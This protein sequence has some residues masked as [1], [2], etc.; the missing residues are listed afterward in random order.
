MNTKQ[1]LEMPKLLATPAMLRTAQENPP[2]TEIKKTWYSNAYPT[3]T[4]RYTTYLRS[5]VKGGILK[6]S[7]FQPQALCCRDRRPVFELYVDRAK[8]KFLTYAPAEKKWYRGKLDRLNWPETYY[9]GGEMWVTVADEKRILRYFNSQSSGGA[10]RELLHFQYD[11]REKEL[12]QRHAKEV[13]PWDEVMKQ[14]RPLPKDWARWVDKVG[15][16]EQFIFYEYRHGGAKP[17]YCSYCEK[18][19]PIENPRHNKVGCCLCCHHEIKFKAVGRVGF[20]DTKDYNVFLLQRADCGFV[21]RSFTV[22]RRYVRGELKTPHVSWRETRRAF[23]THRGA[24]VS[25]YN[26]G[27]YKQTS[28]R[29]VKTDLCGTS[30]WS[31]PTGR[32]Y[33]RTLPDLVKRGLSYTGLMEYMRDGGKADP[34]YYLAVLSK[35]PQLEQIVKA[36]L[37][38]LVNECLLKSYDYL[39]LLKNGSGSLTKMLGINTRELKRLRNSGSGL[40]YLKW[41][42]L[43]HDMDSPIPDE[44]IDWF[45]ENRLSPKDLNFIWDRMR[46]IQVRN[47]MQ[48]QMR[49]GRMG[50]HD[51]LIKWKDYLSMAAQF[52]YDLNDEIVYRTG[53][54]RKQHDALVKKCHEKDRETRARELMQKYPNAERICQT[55]PEKYSYTDGHYAVVAPT[56]LRDI[57]AEGD[58]LHHCIASS[59]RY[60]ERMERHESYILFLR[61]AEDPERHYYTMEVEPNG[62]VRQIRT[63]YDRQNKDIEEAREFLREWQKVLAERLTDA[64]RER[65]KKSSILRME[66]FAE[67]RKEQV[68]VHTGDLAGHLLVDVLTADLLEAA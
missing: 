32:V 38:V 55:L 2:K 35:V 4:C 68:R 63:E 31:L 52:H 60:L 8:D 7:L 25:A 64:D 28:L 37:P 16:P 59:D 13:A 3:V 45:M 14:I 50:I 51:M 43:E 65:A 46:P 12:K 57:L 26:W 36:N 58:A 27:V 48:A 15:I 47:Y 11:V 42:R 20:L 9:S 41:L 54:L 40:E 44:V 53:D 61:E 17:G 19:V 49:K 24:P 30:V 34:E 10:Y 23:Y 21:L 33:T 5:V 22:W 66:E 39:K 67:L 29:W 62:T 6:V 1:L 56:G 18:D